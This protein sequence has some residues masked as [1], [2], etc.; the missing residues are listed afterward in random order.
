[1]MALLQECHPMT[2]DQ[3]AWIS[4]ALQLHGCK[5][6]GAATGGQL[7]SEQL[8]DVL[9]GL[10]LRY[11]AP[12]MQNG[13]RPSSSHHGAHRASAAGSKAEGDGSGSSVKLQVEQFECLASS[14]RESQV[15]SAPSSRRASRC[16]ATAGLM[17]IGDGAGDSSP[18]PPRGDRASSAGAS[19]A[20]AVVPEGTV[21]AVRAQL[22]SPGRG[23]VAKPAA[24]RG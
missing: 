17:Q 10:A 22:A 13:T 21:A 6:L 18:S 8:H 12:G 4:S 24:A 11:T 15:V 19:V 5:R 23:G 3:F 2:A 14:R 9:Q 20:A 7:S 16:E 1:M